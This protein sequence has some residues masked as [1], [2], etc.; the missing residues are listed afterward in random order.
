MTAAMRGAGVALGDRSKLRLLVVGPNGSPGPGGATPHTNPGR[1]SP[2]ANA[3]EDTYMY[4]SRRVQDDAKIFGLSGDMIAL[5]GT[6]LLGLAGYMMQNK[7]S[8]D[9]SETQHN[10]TQET[11][12]QARAEEK[13]GKQLERTMRQNADFIFPFSGSIEHF[14][15]AFRLA[16]A[17]CGLE[18]YIA[19]HGWEIISPPTQPYA[20]V[21][22]TG[23]PTV[24][25]SLLTHPFTEALPPEDI[26]HLAAD[27]AARGLW[28]DLAVH[29][30]LPP[31]RTIVS[32]LKTQACHHSITPPHQN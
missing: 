29:T 28:V 12:A 14:A 20:T 27:P 5:L 23:T 21:M 13:A 18:A 32:L 26:A 17:Q 6:A 7:V 19:V 4:G 24:I 3:A 15:I 1:W 9:A 25:T 30:M 10:V 31:L 2:G 8:R 11:A 16:A 22:T